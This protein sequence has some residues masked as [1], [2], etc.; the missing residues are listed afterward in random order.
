M[1]VKAVCRCAVKELK[2]SSGAFGQGPDRRLLG[3][4]GFTSQNRKQLQCVTSAACFT[5]LG[6]TQATEDSVVTQPELR[7]D[8]TLQ[9]GRGRDV[10]IF[11]M[12]R[13]K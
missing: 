8:N 9:R 12:L 4:P 5:A 3:C 10:F 7:L 11:L 6:S 2:A 13:G 1:A